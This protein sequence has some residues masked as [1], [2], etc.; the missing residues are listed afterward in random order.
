MNKVIYLLSIAPLALS[1][2]LAFASDY[3]KA[4]HKLKEA[5]SQGLVRVSAMELKTLLTN[6]TLD[7]KGESGRYFLT[8]RPDES[9]ERKGQKSGDVLKGKWNI[10]ESKNA[11]CTAFTFKKG[12]EKN[13][14]AVFRAPDGVY[15]FDYDVDLKFDVHVWRQ[16]NGQ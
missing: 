2:G 4:P 15:F 7:F 6:G 3:P 10:D 9:V 14:F 8:F 12:Y 13:C 1:L 16:K 11:Y 5:E